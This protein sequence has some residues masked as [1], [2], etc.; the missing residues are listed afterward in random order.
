M[1]TLNVD[2]RR[3]ALIIACSHYDHSLNNLPSAGQDASELD[4]VLS[5]SK[6]GGFDTQ[7]VLNKPAN[8][9]AYVL[10]TF[11][12]QTA[13][14]D[15]VL[16]HFSGHGL[17]DVDG[18][19]YFACSNTET[20][21]LFS[22]AI[23]AYDV[24]NLLIRASAKRKILVLDCCFGGA[25][26]KGLLPRGDTRA[27]IIEPFREAHGFVVIT[28]SDALQFA[29]E[30]NTINGNVTS[31]VFTR[32]LVDGLETG[33]ADRNGDG[34]IGVY[35]L[36]DYIHDGMRM[37][38]PEQKPE[39]SNFRMQG[40]IYLAKTLNRSVTID[41]GREEAAKG[42][43]REVQLVGQTVFIDVPADTVSGSKKRYHDLIPNESQEKSDLVATFNIINPSLRP[44]LIHAR[45]MALI[46]TLAGITVIFL[47][48][49]G[50]SRSRN[51]HPAVQFLPAT[52]KSVPPQQPTK[53]IKDIFPAQL[54]SQWAY[55][56]SGID[57][58]NGYHL[59]QGQI[60][61][62]VFYLENLDG[63]R[64]I[65]IHQ[66]GHTGNL[67][68]LTDCENKNG[69]G[70]ADIWLA[71]T[72]HCLFERCNYEDAL[73]VC[74]NL[75]AQESNISVVRSSEHN[76]PDFKA[77]FNLGSYWADDDGIHRDDGFYQWKIIKRLDVKVP[78]GLFKNCY[79]MAY[80]V[81]GGE[82]YRY[83]YP[84]VGVVLEESRH[85]GTVIAYRAEL[86]SFSSIR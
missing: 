56:F 29:Y 43:R 61:R 46:I 40:D 66:T 20:S 8:E 27:G 70:A 15:T 53:N 17:K 34:L 67:Q 79:E 25:F 80:R 49:S 83:V 55:R 82:T 63:R 69:S 19:L 26:L 11:L 22:T 23:S 71:D 78:A 13:S 62:R 76:D 44:P 57:Q 28:A 47:T 54:G 50:I 35:E 84:G 64:I 38:R 86:T 65:G 33:A 31:S 85:H 68:I 41:I 36:Y 32:L 73:A 59:R 48:W 16:V 3:L 75:N 51:D 37:E 52:Q 39:I 77:P 60:V 10:E 6:I 14:S 7:V 5:D 21:K 74:D 30:G 2:T 1:K 12:T 9:V 81:G 24:N 18:R 4:R 42:G 58:D 72:G 45:L